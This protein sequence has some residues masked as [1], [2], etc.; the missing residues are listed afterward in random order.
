MA[1][2]TMDKPPAHRI[3]I[4]RQS[5]KEA[6]ESLASPRS[7]RSYVGWFRCQVAR[8]PWPGQ[9]RKQAMEAGETVQMLPTLSAL[10]DACAQSPRNP[11]PPCHRS[12]NSIRKQE[13]NGGKDGGNHSA[14]TL[15]PVSEESSVATALPPALPPSNPR[16][17]AKNRDRWHGGNGFGGDQGQTPSSE[18]DDIEREA[19][20]HEADTDSVSP[21]SKT[22]WD[23]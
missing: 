16:E 4:H 2:L 8:S 10:R 15:P 11:L 20:Q 7:A 22:A 19:I 1:Y 23:L 18:D 21:A 12:E 14:T 6:L 17:T 3:P 5:R 9:V 13:D